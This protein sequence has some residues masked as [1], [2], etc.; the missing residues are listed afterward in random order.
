MSEK[1]YPYEIKGKN[2]FKHKPIPKGRME[3]AIEQTLSMKGAARLLQVSYPTFKKYAKL[4]DLFNPNMGAVGIP[5]TGTTGYG[6]KIQD[7]FDGKHPKYP[8]YKLQEVLIKTGHMIQECNNCGYSQ[9]RDIDNR[10]P[11]LIDFLDN[12]GTNHSPDNM[13]LLC[14][15]CFFLIKPAGKLLTTPKD[16][17]RLRR[18]MWKVFEPTK[19]EKELIKKEEDEKPELPK[20][21]INPIDEEEIDLSKIKDSDVGVN[22]DELFKEM[23]LDEDD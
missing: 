14:Y 11:F 5:K 22:F 8:H 20:E 21:G 9:T 15:C 16:V 3:W 23:G 1:K 2:P 10:G 13:R 19:K 18:Q 4:Y 17:L 12:D 7:L 6:V